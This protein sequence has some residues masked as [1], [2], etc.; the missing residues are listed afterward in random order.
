M[1]SKRGSS[2]SPTEKKQIL[3]ERE[4]ALYAWVGHQSFRCRAGTQ[5]SC[6]NHPMI[7]GAGGDGTREFAGPTFSSSQDQ[8]K[9]SSH[10]LSEEKS[11]LHVLL[12]TAQATLVGKNKTMNVRVVIDAGST[13]SFVKQTV[14]KEMELDVVEK[15][16]M[17]L[18]H[19]RSRNMPP[20]EHC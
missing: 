2:L 4:L 12:M 16:N 3:R 9:D 6:G 14:V 19:W 5:C 15:R 11:G 10:C 13:T 18:R 8:N 1:G 7:C 17:R 20:N